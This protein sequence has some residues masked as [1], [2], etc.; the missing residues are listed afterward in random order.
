MR[1]ER[2]LVTP[3]L[4]TQLLTK[5]SSNRPM[6]DR[7]VEF[8]KSQMLK[9]LYKETGDTIKIS[10]TDKLLDGQH[11]LKAI[12]KSGISVYQQ[13]AYDVPD[14]VFTVLDIGKLRSSGDILTIAGIKNGAN[15][16]SIVGFIKTFERG[17]SD[18]N[19]TVK[20]NAEE[21]ISFIKEHPELEDI[22]KFV[23]KVYT[24]T[25]WLPPSLLGA[26]YYTLL[27]K[28]HSEQTIINFFEQYETGLGL[29]QS[30]P[31]YV[32]RDKLIRNS[33]NKTKYRIADKVALI[34]TAWNLYIKGRYANQ[35]N[36]RINDEFPTI[37]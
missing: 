36:M 7:N 23:Y 1:I 28:N 33:T 22:Y 14:D 8:I 35:G 9:G 6:N 20:E 24:R 34:I 18:F 27:T 15:M 37:I 3:E 21:K 25:K 31:V 19:K 2:V 13:I 10:V 17:S 26:F 11:R 12:E 30:S 5:N 32:L 4:A 29:N 16:S